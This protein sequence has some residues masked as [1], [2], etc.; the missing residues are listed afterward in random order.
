M[1]HDSTSSFSANQLAAARLIQAC[2]DQGLHHFFVA[3]GSRCT[4]L[5]IAIANHAEARVVQ[6][7]DERGLAFACLGFARA[8]GRAGVFV[9]TSGTAVAN[10]LPAVVEASNDQVPLLLLTADR[11]PE[12]RETGANQ[13]IDQVKIYGDFARWCF[14]LPCPTSDTTASFLRSTIRH[15]ASRAATGPVHINC[16]FREPFESADAVR[17]ESEP[18]ATKNCRV[19]LEHVVKLPA[20]KTLVMAGSSSAEAARAAGN[21]ADRLNA[22]FFSDVSNGVRGLAY[23]LALMS[24]ELPVPDRV[25]HVGGRVV[26]KRWAT[27]L[28][29]HPEIR[30]IHYW[31]Y[32]S[33]LD[34][35]HALP[36]VIHG[37]LKTLCDNTTCDNRS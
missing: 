18:P 7:F 26:S 4:P 16:M 35:D 10:A 23:D 13:T 12:L 20:G 21:M 1:Q 37:D 36:E 27:F 15:A 32:E 19:T 29:S 28:K 8:T 24:N 2:I 9:C 30:Q 11:P 14:D 34:P 22:P 5:T 17:C 6:H 33:R 31:P 25:V 3:P